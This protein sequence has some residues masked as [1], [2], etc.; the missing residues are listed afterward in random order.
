ML[1]ALRHRP[2]RR[3]TLVI[4]GGD[5]TVVGT[6][7]A[8]RWAASTAADSYALVVGSTTGSTDRY[9]ANVGNVLTYTLRLTA[10]TYYA[11]VVTYSGSTA[12]STYVEETVT[13]T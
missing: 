1:L 4:S 8:F 7:V 2:E 13:L 10:G 9:D 12:L 6:D 11:R 5:S 3:P